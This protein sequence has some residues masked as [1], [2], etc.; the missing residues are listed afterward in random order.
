MKEFTDMIFEELKRNYTDSNM[1]DGTMASTKTNYNDDDYKVGYS[2][3]TRLYW[4]HVEFTCVAQK[5]NFEY[6]NLK[7]IYLD[8]DNKTIFVT[9]SD[10]S[11]FILNYTSGDRFTIKKFEQINKRVITGFEK[12]TVEQLSSG[13]Y[14]PVPIWEEVEGTP[15]VV[16]LNLSVNDRDG[17]SV[18]R[19]A[20]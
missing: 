11:N 14:V 4:Y 5:K 17:Y 12:A 20:R 7:R 8:M 2:V 6:D 19:N 10:D 15:T 13:D 3:D 1:E 16:P 9:D 18:V